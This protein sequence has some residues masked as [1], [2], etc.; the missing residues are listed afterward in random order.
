MGGGERGWPVAV[1]GGNLAHHANAARDEEQ[2]IC[3]RG[4][5]DGGDG[6]GAGAGPAHDR[7]GTS[8][9][10]GHDCLQEQLDL[11]CWRMM[12]LHFAL[13]RLNRGP[14]LAILG[15]SRNHAP[16]RFLHIERPHIPVSYTHLTL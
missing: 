15:D 3:D 7:L 11:L 14:A 9:E 10:R 4:R 2:R 16:D 8:V 6:E 12:A 1:T 13:K 5:A